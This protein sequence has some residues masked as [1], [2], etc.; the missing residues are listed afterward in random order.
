MNQYKDE[1]AG[2][3]LRPMTEEDTDLIVAWRNSDGVRRHFIY[4]AMFTRE[5]HLNW[6]NSVIKPGKASQMII[7]ESATDEP[8]GSVYIRDIDRE[9]R[10]GEYGI[11]IGE[12]AARGRGVGTAAAMLMIRYAFEELKLHRLFL[13]VYADNLR[14]VRSYEKAGFV[15]EA[16]LKDDVY[17]N[18]AFRDIILMAVLNPQ[19]Y[20][21]DE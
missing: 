5:G 17:V 19:D 15:R 4:Q 20:R 14:A 16:Y 1:K 8:L 13:R 7:C 18:G 10:K 9:H 3:Y 21:E 2:I 6:L 11:F 12:D